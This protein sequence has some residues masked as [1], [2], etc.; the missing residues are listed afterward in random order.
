VVCDLA[1][2]LANQ[3]TLY[4]AAIIPTAAIIFLIMG[5]FTRMKFSGT[6]LFIGFC[7]SL[8]ACSIGQILPWFVSIPV[9]AV[10]SFVVLENRRGA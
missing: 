6:G 1:C 10:S 4:I 5:L 9:I 8:I 3:G 7:L 2:A